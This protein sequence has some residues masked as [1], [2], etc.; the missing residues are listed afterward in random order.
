MYLKSISGGPDKF[1]LSV[2]FPFSTKGN[3]SVLYIFSLSGFCCELFLI[4]DEYS[5]G[6][7]VKFLIRLLRSDY[8]GHLDIKEKVVK[9][10]IVHY[11]G[12]FLLHT[13]ILIV[14]MFLNNLQNANRGDL[15]SN[16]GEYFVV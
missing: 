3:R 6:L 7:N 14:V 10:L 13:C 2:K 15:H 1:M 16:C 5:I 4:H 9:F 8:F 11:Q 12:Q